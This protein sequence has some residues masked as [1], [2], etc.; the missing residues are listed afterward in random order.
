MHT[1]RRIFGLLVLSAAFHALA[2]T[3]FVNVVVNQRWP[4]SEKV[5]VDFVLSGDVSDVEVSA[6]WSG[7]ATPVVLGTLSD[8][9]PG[10]NRFT[11]D[12]ST[13]PFAGQTLADFT[14]S[15]TNVVVDAQR[16]VVIDL[17]NGGYEYLANTPSG[18]WADEHK[19]TKMVFRRIPAGTYAI[20]E[21]AETFTHL[22]FADSSASSYPTLWNRR[23]V[24]FTSAFYV[25]VFKYTKAQHNCLQG[26][27]AGVDFSPQKISYYSLRGGLDKADW[28]AQGYTVG[29]DSI[30]A[31][32]RAKTQPNGLVVDLCEEDQ[33]EVAARAGTTT[34]LPN[35]F[36]ASD[37]LNAFT[38]KLNAISAWYGTTGSAEP[39]VAL[40]APNGWGLYDVVGLMGE[41][42]LDSAVNIGTKSLPRFGLAD[43]RTDPVGE[44][45]YADGSGYRIF[46]TGAANYE[47]ASLYKILPCSRQMADPASEWT[48]TTRFCIHLS[49]LG[50]LSFP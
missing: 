4:W 27:A 6:V 8:C 22:G 16:Y 13:S 15:L 19:S 17:V 46:K 41:W 38:N 34:I 9:Q 37:D 29:A 47:S 5:D 12:P 21:P 26:N 20:G 30:V 28:P 35:G 10:H 48:C 18:G 39:S 32:L 25:G 33:W 24:T 49:P 31:L 36:T 45:R 1:L 14:V 2:A 11:W 43:G 42:M 44:S 50:N 23:T 7:H 40:F 3:E